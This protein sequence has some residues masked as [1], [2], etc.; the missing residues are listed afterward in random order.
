MGYSRAL[1]YCTVPHHCTVIPA[2]AEPMF[3]CLYLL[4]LNVIML[5]DA[6]NSLVQFIAPSH[7]VIKAF[8]RD[9]TDYTA[10]STSSY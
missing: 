2:I 4:Q 1:M 6:M 10:V 7:G 5:Q 8:K 9:K 3:Q